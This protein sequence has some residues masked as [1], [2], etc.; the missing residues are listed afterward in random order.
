MKKLLNTLY[1]TTQKSYLGKDGETVSVYRDGK[2]VARIPVHTLSGIVCFGNVGMSPFLMGFCGEKEVGVSFL[3]ERGRFLARVAGPVSGNVLVR[4]T[5]YRL[6]DEPDESA[7]LARSCVI[8]KVANCR[9]VLSRALRDHRDK[10]DADAVQEATTRLKATLKELA[11]PRPLDTV[12]GLE[13]DAARAYFGVLDHLIITN[14]DTFCFKGRSRRPP[15]DMVN[16]MLSFVYTL[17]VHDVRSALEAMGLD[18]AVGFLHRD[19]PGRPGLALD[20]MEEFRAFVADRLV[21]SLI[22]QRQVSPSG[23]QTLD[24]GAVVMDDSTRKVVI[25][26]YQDR[27]Q[28]EV[29]HPFLKEKAKIGQLFFVQAQLLNRYFRKDLDG[30]PPFVWR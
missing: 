10:L 26:A 15:Q 12:R 28:D 23:F 17:L 20:M 18:P 16:A 9:A 5:Q 29:C 2:V 8:G 13:G 22:N 27:K 6:A 21:L 1:V 4:R 25:T 30:Y 7:E 3:T 11:T 19:R 24:S 14:K